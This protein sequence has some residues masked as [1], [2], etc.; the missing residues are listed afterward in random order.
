M[1]LSVHSCTF[2]VP[3]NKSA[4]STHFVQVATP[5]LCSATRFRDNKK[6]DREEEGGPRPIRG[7]H[8]YVRTRRVYF[9]GSCLPHV[10][11]CWINDRSGDIDCGGDRVAPSP[12]SSFSFKKNIQRV[13]A[14]HVA[15]LLQDDGKEST[16]VP[17]PSSSPPPPPRG[18]G[19]ILVAGARS[20]PPHARG[21]LLGVP[22]I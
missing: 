1:E 16:T 22:P 3:K 7:G 8:A 10:F 14:K 6:S 18:C 21:S 4:F 20:L 13:I 2:F 9:V 17:E 5:F 15:N 19:I 12:S 11:I